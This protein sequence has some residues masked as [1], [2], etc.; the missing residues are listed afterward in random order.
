MFMLR[1][2]LLTRTR[3]LRGRYC[4]ECNYFLFRLWFLLD[5]YAWNILCRD[6]ELPKVSRLDFLL[7]FCG[8]RLHALILELLN[9]VMQYCGTVSD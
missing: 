6:I 5:F 2:L 7:L 4:V 1:Y 3:C 8:V 9:S